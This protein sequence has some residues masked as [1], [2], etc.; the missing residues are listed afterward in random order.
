LRFGL[1]SNGL[2]AFKESPMRWL[3]ISALLL[4]VPSVGSAQGP[5]SLAVF[6]VD[7]TP[8]LGV[9]VA[10]APA[11]SIEDPLSARGIVLWS[12]SQKPIVLCAVDW[13]GIAN[14]SHWYWKETLA[15]AA[16]TTPDRVAVHTLHQHDG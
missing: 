11:R 9:P 12:G 8:K 7:A 1:T 2:R 6:K 5:L 13:I 14:A 10:Y 15:A 16:G 4:F 3:T